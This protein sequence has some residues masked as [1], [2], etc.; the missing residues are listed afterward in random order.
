MY[1]ECMVKRVLKTI[2][3]LV[4]AYIVLASVYF[5]VE[6]C[7]L[8]PRAGLDTLVEFQREFPEFETVAIVVNEKPYHV[9]FGHYLFP[10]DYSSGYLFDEHGDLVGWSPDAGDVSPLSEY[11]LKARFGNERITRHP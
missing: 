9:V 4:I 6:R 8:A 11:W 2:V 7:Y 3:G 10:N 5:I 1:G